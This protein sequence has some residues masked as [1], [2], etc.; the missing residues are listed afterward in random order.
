MYP[1]DDTFI[2]A[3]V[4]SNHGGNVET[5][6]DLFR[7]AKR[8]GASAVK[9]QKRD[10]KTLFTKSAYNR[11]YLNRN[12]YGKTYGEHREALEFGWPEYVELKA[13][14]EEL[15]IT[16]FSTP[17]DFKSVDFLERLDVPLYKIASAD[18]T[19]TPL[20]KYVVETGK[21]VIISTGG[22]S[23]EDSDRVYDIV[24]RPKTA[25]L[26]CVATYPN[27]AEE[28][29]LLVIP[30]MKK[31]YPELAAV[32]L[33][34][35]YN[36]ICMAEAAYILGARVIEKHF[37]LNHSWKGTDHALSLEPQGMESLVHNINRIS[38]AMGKADK[39][40]LDAEKSAI[41][42]MGKSLW[43]SR[44][45]KANEPLTRE[46]MVIRTPG[47]GIPPHQ[48]EEV[49]GKITINDLSTDAPVKPDDI[50]PN[51]WG[52]SGWPA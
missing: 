24:D 44:P 38:V 11:P 41:E 18:C 9:L 45:I 49:I 3:E 8:C 42:K 46:N 31:R 14:A 15:G 37:T 30:E 5:C 12:S 4:G 2:I 7:E 20:I 40:A 26:H 52:V 27:Q 34:D 47:G 10:N 32:G 23:W 19:N 17:F 28:M 25:F 43:P 35:H 6:K 39:I 48:I 33:S 22:A 21:P 29:N 50:Q 13:Y 51:V 16:F 1:F 36:G